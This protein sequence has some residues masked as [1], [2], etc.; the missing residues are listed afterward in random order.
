MLSDF[1]FLAPAES[2][3][4]LAHVTRLK[5]VFALVA[6]P[7]SAKRLALFADASR[8]G[9][10][11]HLEL[12]VR[13][14]IITPVSVDNS[15]EYSLRGSWINADEGRRGFQIELG[16]WRVILFSAGS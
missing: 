5:I 11:Y 13:A 7:A 3:T 12:L 15:I 10:F 8:K 1:D 14:G 16:P 9:I 2:L 4:V 6:G